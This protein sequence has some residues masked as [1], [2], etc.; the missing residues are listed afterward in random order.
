MHPMRWL[1]LHA[2]GAH[3]GGRAR[4][5][6]YYIPIFYLGS[7]FLCATSDDEMKKKRVYV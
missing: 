1:N 2:L 5:D 3:L 6:I 7:A 4:R